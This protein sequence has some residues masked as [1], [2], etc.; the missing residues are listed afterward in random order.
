MWRCVFNV[1]LRRRRLMEETVALM[2]GC[3]DRSTAG[4]CRIVLSRK[5]EEED[6]GGGGRREG[7]GEGEAE[8]ISS[9]SPN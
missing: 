9:S 4:Q 1:V 8:G 6:G 7:G 5:E 3:V 2:N